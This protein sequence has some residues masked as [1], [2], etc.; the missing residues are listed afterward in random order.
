MASPRRSARLANLRSWL[1]VGGPCARPA[2]SDGLVTSP[3][4][5]E[6]PRLRYPDDFAGVNGGRVGAGVA[7]VLVGPTDEGVAALPSG[8]EVI[9]RTAKEGVVTGAASKRIISR[10]SVKPVCPVT[11]G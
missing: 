6:G 5:R 8:E 11:S 9:T 7:D 3:M 4:S 2:M 1:N 10:S